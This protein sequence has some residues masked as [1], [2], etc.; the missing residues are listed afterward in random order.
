MISRPHTL[1]KTRLSVLIPTGTDHD[2]YD[3]PICTARPEFDFSAHSTSLLSS[4]N[5]SKRPANSPFYSPVF[6]A[7]PDGYHAMSINHH[8]RTQAEQSQKTPTPMDRLA[9][10]SMVLSQ[11]APRGAWGRKRNY[12]VIAARSPI[13]DAHATDSEAATP[14]ARRF[15]FAPTATQ[16]HHTTSTF[17]LP[18]CLPPLS[19]SELSRMNSYPSPPIAPQQSCPHNGT[20]GE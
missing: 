2:A 13:E 3:T 11:K 12:T 5:H 14:I 7:A 10:P 16:H 9:V 19:I 6:A 18:L 8:P 15:S 4:S 20:G 17:T 1:P